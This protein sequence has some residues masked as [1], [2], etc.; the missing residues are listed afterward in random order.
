MWRG[1]LFNPLGFYERQDVN[2]AN[3]RFIE[4]SGGTLAVP[5]NPKHVFEHGDP[6]TIQ[7]LDLSWTRSKES[8]GLKDPRLCITLHSWIQH[9]LVPQSQLRLV[10]VER[11]IESA[12]RSACNFPVITQYAQSEEPKIVGEMLARYAAAATWHV[13]QVGAPAV[14]IRYEDLVRNPTDAVAGLARFLG[15]T[16]HRRIAHA[17]QAVGK[18]R[19]LLRYYPK[20]Y[21]VHAPLKLLR[22]LRKAI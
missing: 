5:G 15:V 12:T 14:T 3:T 8:W 11:A 9:G 10:H 7:S 21:M 17:A 6:K 22:V 2:V 18:Q 1:N 16:D 19:A 20:R 13:E 4:S